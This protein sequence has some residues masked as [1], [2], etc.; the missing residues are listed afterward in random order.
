M[1]YRP[2]CIIAAMLVAAHVGHAQS[3]SLEALLERLGAYL[4]EYES[5]AFELVAEERYEQWIKR[6]S[7]Y[8]GATV[9]R[10][11]LDSTYFLV[12]LPDGQAWYGFRDVTS[13]DGRA[14]SV[15]GRSMAELLSERTIDAV[16]EALAMT[17]A[18]AR[19]NIGGVYRTLNV[20]LQTLE[21]FV[22]KHHTRFAFHEAGRE[23]VKGQQT[24]VVAFQER[25]APTLI[26]DGFGGDVFSSGR[27]WIDPAAGAV[28]RT[29]LSFAGPAA[30]YL[31]E[32]VIRVD[33]ERDSRVQ[34]LVPREM[35]ETYGL[36]VEV[37]HGRASYRNYRKFETTGRMVTQPE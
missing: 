3:S 6:R 18:N 21:L 8:G 17:R 34:L 27:I 26:S 2:L 23:K 16:E 5:K 36:D 15:A 35:E 20:P 31:K 4:Q 29:E 37:V 14:V 28:L 24:A 13:V 1:G 19:Y 33:Y 7:G 22:P 32:N 11:K 30:A 9:Q 25:S 10:R 12:H